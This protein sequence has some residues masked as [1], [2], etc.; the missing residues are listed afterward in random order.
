MALAF[1]LPAQAV[2]AVD[3][4]INCTGSKLHWWKGVHTS[5]TAGHRHGTSGTAKAYTFKQCKNP[6]FLSSS[7]TFYFSNIVPFNGGAYDIIQIGEGKCR[8]L[9]CASGQHYYSAWG[10]S[11]STPGCQT[12]MSREPN[13]GDEGAYVAGD[14]DFKVWH[15]SNV[16]NFYVGVNAVGAVAE[17][18]ICWSPDDSQWFSEVEDD[19]SQLGGTVAAPFQVIET[20]YATAENGG[21]TYT[22]FSPGSCNWSPSVH[23]FYCYDNSSTQY[24]TYTDR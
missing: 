13:V 10:R 6:P 8:G 23:P 16:Y 20:N 4:N 22:S 2:L 11:Q 5:G 9:N 12:F 21:F 15:L 1:L 7:S 14:H 3:Q 18:N 19:G 17:Q 24:R